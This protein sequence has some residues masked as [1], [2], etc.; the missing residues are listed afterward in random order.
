MA[1]IISSLTLVHDTENR[2]LDMSGAVNALN[3]SYQLNAY[4]GVTTQW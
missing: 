1:R 2:L 4:V 3:S